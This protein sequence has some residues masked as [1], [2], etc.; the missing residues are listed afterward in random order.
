M[1][2]GRKLGHGARGNAGA[3][4]APRAASPCARAQGQQ[5]CRNVLIL[6]RAVYRTA[7]HRRRLAASTRGTRYTRTAG[8]RA[9]SLRCP[10]VAQGQRS[11]LRSTARR[12]RVEPNFARLPEHGHRTFAHHR[13]YSS[14][15]QRTQRTQ[16]Q[17]E[18]PELRALSMAMVTL[19]HDFALLCVL[20]VLCG[21]AFAS[22]Q[23]RLTRTRWRTT[24]A[25]PAPSPAC[26]A[27]SGSRSSTGT[28]PAPGR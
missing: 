21:Q 11:K 5:N 27:G 15:P 17:Q 4:S 22:A 13:S 3:T 26:P 14:C 28:R 24:P 1:R 7:I 9:P 20:S 10:N 2:I 19:T 18:H 25:P 6:R 23:V 16:R 8:L 12:D